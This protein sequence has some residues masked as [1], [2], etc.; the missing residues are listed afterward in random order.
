MLRSRAGLLLLPRA[1]CCWLVEQDKGKQQQERSKQHQPQKKKR[2]AMAAA[3]AV[4]VAS[5]QY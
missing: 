2:A 1:W 4:T 5:L 3:P